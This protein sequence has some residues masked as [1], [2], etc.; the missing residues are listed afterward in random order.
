MFV[1]VKTLAERLT[2]PC[3]KNKSVSK[4]TSSLGASSRC[5]KLTTNVACDVEE[6]RGQ[7]LKTIG[8]VCIPSA[9]TN[10]IPL[11][12]TDNIKHVKVAWREHSRVE[13]ANTIGIE[14]VPSSTTHIILPHKTNFASHGR[15]ALGGQYKRTT[16]VTDECGNRVIMTVG[17]LG[18][19]ESDRNECVLGFK[20]SCMGW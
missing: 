18:M 5:T 3:H 1:C 19:S 11:C 20:E 13:T 7:G 4:Q 15:V 17:R 14:C 16:F 12:A 6:N 9:V 10:T 8:Y 2:T